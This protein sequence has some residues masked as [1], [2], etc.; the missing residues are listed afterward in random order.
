MADHKCRDYRIGK[1]EYFGDKEKGLNCLPRIYIP[2]AGSHVP[3]RQEGKTFV[4]SY[5]D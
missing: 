5:G 4:H 1:E 2:L 3:C